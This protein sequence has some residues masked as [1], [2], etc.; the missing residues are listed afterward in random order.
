[1]SLKLRYDFDI[2][3]DILINL[4]MFIGTTYYIS[5]EDSA[6]PQKPAAFIFFGTK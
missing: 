2:K 4:F 5:K 1:M 6:K 3:I